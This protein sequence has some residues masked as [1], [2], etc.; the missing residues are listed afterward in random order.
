MT[1]LEEKLTKL[2]KFDEKTESQDWQ[3]YKDEWVKSINSL[4]STIMYKYFEDF[5]SKGLMKFAIIPV[6]RSE[7]YVGEYVTAILEITLANNKSLIMEPVAAVTS[8]Y[9]GRLDFYLRGNILKKVSI[10]R[11]LLGENKFVPQS[12]YEWILAKSYDK[13]YH[14]KL[15]KV[16]IEK[17]IEE[18]LS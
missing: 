4:H 12:K 17:L 5:A 15:D 2:K 14:F 7:A 16:Q 3:I 10:Y 11:D 9:Y 6:I 13:E 1:T 18:W 8:D